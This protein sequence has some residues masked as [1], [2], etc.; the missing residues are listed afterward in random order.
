MF[1]N[2]EEAKIESEVATLGGL[3]PGDTWPRICME[4]LVFDLE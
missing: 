2:V 1:V 4:M 3:D